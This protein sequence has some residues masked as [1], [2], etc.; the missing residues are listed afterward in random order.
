M[1]KLQILFTLLSSEQGPIPHRQEL[2]ALTAFHGYTAG[3]GY[4]CTYCLCRL[5]ITFF[6]QI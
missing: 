5:L 4:S 2:P 6:P 1:E 3:M